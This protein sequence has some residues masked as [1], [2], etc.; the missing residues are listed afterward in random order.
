MVPTCL[1]GQAASARQIFDGSEPVLRIVVLVSLALALGIDHSWS[2]FAKS[3]FLKC[4]IL[5][6]SG[7]AAC[8]VV[9]L[10]S[11]VSWKKLS[12][13]LPCQHRP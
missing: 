11:H 2:G 1:A 12:P 9:T 7:D 10:L 3:L 6:L 4:F 5:R 8:V 13:T